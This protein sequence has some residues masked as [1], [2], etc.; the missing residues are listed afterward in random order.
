MEEDE[1]VLNL[2]L[3]SSP[4][5][6][7]LLRH[8][9]KLNGVVK[10]TDEVGRN[11]YREFLFCEAY[12]TIL[13][14]DSVLSERCMIAPQLRDIFNALEF[15]AVKA[16]QK[17]RYWA[18]G[19][20]AAEL[21]LDSESP[22]YLED[23]VFTEDL[24]YRAL[25]RQWRNCEYNAATESSSMV[26]GTSCT[27]Q[28]EGDEGGFGLVPKL[29]SNGFLET[30]QICL[31]GMLEASADQDGTLQLTDATGSI[32]VAVVGC[33]PPSMFGAIVQVTGFIGVA[34]IDQV[35]SARRFV[36]FKADNMKVIVEGPYSVVALQTRDG[37]DAK[38]QTAFFSLP[39]TD[40][41]GETV[42]GFGAC[43][44][45]IVCSL[46]HGEN[47]NYRWTRSWTW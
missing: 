12:S 18:T 8:V 29:G 1:D 43:P 16:Y 11:I 32:S 17:R 2:T 7:G 40:S 37:L 47:F 36:S 6:P 33:M 4:G 27:A 23:E 24:I 20:D 22:F 26:N 45:K 19:M 21:D 39:P 30:S 3:G 35:Q 31:V 15:L 10:R 28:S 13:R 42:T 9:M 34:E 41:G 14:T 38:S 46:C 25:A 5:D 44:N